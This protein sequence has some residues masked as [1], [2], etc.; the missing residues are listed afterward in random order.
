MF[1]S[2][3]YINQCLPAVRSVNVLGIVKKYDKIMYFYSFQ[4][5]ILDWKAAILRLRVYTIIYQ[6]KEIIPFV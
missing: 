3:S 6:W 4:L 2:I 5:N 1:T